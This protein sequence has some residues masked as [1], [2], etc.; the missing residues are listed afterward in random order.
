VVKREVVCLLR[1]KANLCRREKEEIGKGKSFGKAENE[2][3]GGR[4]GPRRAARED[5]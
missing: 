3:K 4:T 1:S 5:P 2:G